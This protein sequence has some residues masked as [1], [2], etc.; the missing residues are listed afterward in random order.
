MEDIMKKTIIGYALMLVGI[1]SF[2]T[3]FVCGYCFSEALAYEATQC[4]NNTKDEGECKN[5]CDCMDTDAAGRTTCRDNCI[6]KKDFSSNSDFITV[7]APSTL[8]PDGDYSAALNTSSEAECKLYCDGSSALSC[9]DRR[10]CRDE[11]NAKYSGGNDDDSGGDQGGGEISIEQAI[12]DLAQGNTIA[13]DGMAFLTGDLCSNTFLPPGKVADFSGFQYLRDTDPSLLG[14]NTAF[15]TIVAYNMWNILTEAQ[16]TILI[17]LEKTQTE[18]IAE[19]G[20]GRLPLVKAFVR[21][22]EGDI[23]T[24]STGLVRSKVMA[25]SADLY[26]LD[27]QIS[28]DRAS[29]LGTILRGMSTEQKAQLDA[30]K[31]SGITNW[32][33]P[34]DDEWKALSMGVGVSTY[35]SEM[36]SWY[37]GGVEADTY[38]CPERQ[39]TYFGSFYMKDMPAMVAAPGTV[40]ISSSL[41]AD[42]GTDFLNVLDTTQKALVTGLVDIQRNDLYEIVTTRR[43]ISTQL[44]RFMTE[45]S[46]DLTTVL[47]LA[48]RYGELDGEIIYNYANNFV[49]VSKTM[50]AAQKAQLLPILAKYEWGRIDCEGYGYLYSEKLKTDPQI[51]TIHNTDDF[52]TADSTAVPY[53]WFSFSPSTP[54]ANQAVSFT[55]SSSG[56]PTSWSWS[57]GDGSTNTSQNPTHTYTAAGDYTVTLTATNAN[58]TGESTSRTITV[59]GGSSSEGVTAGTITKIAEGT[60]FIFT[61]GPAADASGNVFFSDITAN[62]IYK[63]STEGQ[64]T[65]F[66]TNT[67]GANGLFFDKSGNLLAC[68]GINKRLVSITMDENVTVLADKY[69]DKTFNEPND[70]W[71]DPK[72]GVYFSDP[73][74]FGTSLVQDGEHVYYLT[75]KRDNVLRVVADMT[76]PN[77]IIGTA[78]GKTLYV[79]DHGAGKTYKY[80]VAENGSLTDK[81]LFVSVGSDGMTIDSEGNIYLTNENGVQVYTSSGSLIETINVPL[82]PTNVCFGGKDGKTL[83][84]TAKTAVYSLAMNVKGISYTASVSYGLSDVISILKIFV[85]AGSATSVSKDTDINGDGRIGLEEVIYFLKKLADFI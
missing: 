17:N 51:E 28:Y 57:F 2:G 33:K 38:F 46:V 22:L 49:Q 59:T 71:I 21:L 40:T 63:W 34:T 72:G 31:A 4:L 78:D 32:H 1:L 5:C 13:F 43:L 84:I 52:F 29:A 14:H 75:P 68:E 7:T 69:S 6:A 61:E 16:R 80:T 12:S 39:G 30:L 26:E 48:R 47:E 79:A 77:G 64:L 62:K 25:Y 76:S 45:S 70:L 65:T 60:T 18:Q 56:T 53:A 73:L 15:V 37:A 85:S 83:F 82:D 8:G 3:A 9:G 10:Y 11:C 50:T 67:G 41:T 44:R 66:K 58:G 19:Y 23:P 27:G 24:G 55:D 20:Y 81:T 74:Y 54:T 35:T 42:V 36:Y